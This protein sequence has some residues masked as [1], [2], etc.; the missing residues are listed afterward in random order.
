MSTLPL[1][2]GKISNPDSGAGN[3]LAKGRSP[4]IPAKARKSKRSSKKESAKA[5]QAPRLKKPGGRPG[6][7][8]K[9]DLVIEMLKRQSGASIADIIAKTGWQPHSVRGFFSG[10]VRKKLKLPLVSDVG[11]DGVRRYRIAATVSSKA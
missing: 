4:G 5:S 3:H 6:S 1:A 8:S 9:Q 11:K 7:G 2:T 10:L